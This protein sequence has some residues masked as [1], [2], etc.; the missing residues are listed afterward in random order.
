M[1]LHTQTDGFNDLRDDHAA[2]RH[3]STRP[4]ARVV[5]SVMFAVVLLVTFAGA[6]LAE[7]PRVEPLWPAGAPGAI[8][9]EPA[10]KPTLTIYLPPADKAT[11]AAVVICPGGGYGGLAI[12]HEGVEVARW[13]NSIGVAGFI[14][15]YRHAPRYRHPAPLQDALR[16]IR[17]VRA[18]AS[19]FGVQGSKIGILGFSAGGHLASSAATLF[20][21]ANPAAE[22]P[23]MRVGSRPD[24]A[25]LIYPVISFAEPCRHSGSLR[26][27]LGPEPDPA[28]IELLST[29]RQVTTRTPP[30]FLVHT[31][32]DGG[33]PAEN[34]ILFYMALFRLKVPAEMHI[35][36][37]GPHGFGL[38]SKEKGGNPMVATWPKACAAW[39][40]HR[41]ILPAAPAANP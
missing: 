33:V 31:T 28:L 8:G 14:L 36:E 39:L 10:D 30:T 13:L 2:L 20:E 38:G 19:E 37:A 6:G 11:G 16:A 18:R 21:D 4:L 15:R 23:I 12:D 17:T 25:V 9:D 27:L 5:W 32:A 35:Y 1:N 7:E 29:D 34:S 40:A 26:N 24:F 41:G 22:D 3:S